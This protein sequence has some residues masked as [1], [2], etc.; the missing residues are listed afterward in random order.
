[1]ILIDL[2]TCA[3]GYS[4][5]RW[6]QGQLPAAYRDKVDVIFD[7]IDTNVWRPYPRDQRRL[8]GRTFPDGLKLVTYAARG[9]EAMRGFDIF[10]EV[11]KRILAARSDVLF[12]VAG[13]DKVWYGGDQKL[14]GG[15]PFG[16]WVFGRG[17]IDLSKFVMFGRLDPPEL[18]RLFSM[19]DL[20]VYL[21][22]PFILSWS[23]LDA[24]ACG[25]TVLAS[26]TGPVREVIR[27]GETGLLA[28]FFDVD[29]LA[30]EA[31]RVLDAPDE[32]RPLGKAG[33]ELVRERYSLD[34]C[35]PQM[36][37]LYERV[38]GAR[39]GAPPAARPSGPS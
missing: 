8:R 3:A 26:D 20:H 12:L 4:P 37:R 9:F 1:M 19:S 24:L 14:T 33:M 7:G 10:V 36:V 18:A 35:V 25:A 29:K 27:H 2:E 21:T 34:V 6:Q 11:A 13:E 39:G 28:G 38:A 15:Q 23:L 17:G 16:Q 32:F 5:T 22:V 30:E 31:L